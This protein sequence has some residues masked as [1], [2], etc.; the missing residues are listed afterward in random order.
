MLAGKTFDYYLD[1]KRRKGQCFPDAELRTLKVGKDG[2]AK[3]TLQPK[4]G[5]ILQEK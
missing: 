2:K 4:G 3:V 5:I 1:S